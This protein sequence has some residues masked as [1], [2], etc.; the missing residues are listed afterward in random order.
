MNSRRD[1]HV[2]LA[3][4]ENYFEG[5]LTTAWSIARNC[6]RPEDLVL[7][8]L[9]G[10]IS[11]S[12]WDF[13]I[14]RLASFKSTINRI[15]VDQKASF[16]GFKAY[17]GTGRMTYARLL[18]PDLLPQTENIIYSDVDIV[19][20]VDIAELWD[21]LDASAV[22]HFVAKK[23]RHEPEVEWFEQNGFKFE[24]QN[25]FSAGMIVMNLRKFREEK[26]HIKMLDAITNSNGDVPCYDETALNAFMFGRHDRC[27]IHKRW[28]RLSGGRQ[29]D[30]EHDGFVL[31]YGSDAPWRSIHTYHHF[32]N[33]QHL[34]WHRFHAEAR[35]ITTW[36]SLRM[37][38]S[39]L[40]I[41]SCRLL[42]LMAANSAL[43]LKFLHLVMTIKGN[44]QKI[45]C[46][47]AYAVKMPFKNVRPKLMPFGK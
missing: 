21:A 10:G 46:L 26:L 43:F 14:S 20:I 6:S 19:W 29:D 34:I 37:F 32:L 7:H 42:Y 27:E 22:L 24:Q 40:D 23:N 5:L 44:K 36:Q 38:N 8:I 45:P 33:D 17:R 35:S 18:L 2:A 25:R 1:I 9:D 39:P 12:S 30:L 41:I 4:D 11:A 28:Q 47:D 13:L 16:D 15:P 3:S 31:H